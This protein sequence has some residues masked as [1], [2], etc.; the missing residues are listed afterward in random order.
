MSSAVLASFHQDLSQMLGF[1]EAAVYASSSSKLFW[2]LACGQHVQLCTTRTVM[3]AAK[4]QPASFR[5]RC[6]L[7]D[8]R[9]AADTEASELELAARRAAEQALADVGAMGGAAAEV[10]LLREARA[11][12]YAAA[13][14]LLY[15]QAASGRLAFLLVQVDGAQHFEQSHAFPGQ[16]VQAQQERDGAF[17]AAAAAQ[18]LSVARLHHADTEQ[19]GAVLAAALRQLLSGSR[20]FI[21][22]S[23]SYR[24]PLSPGQPCTIQFQ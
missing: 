24:Q 22:F 11:Q 14:L 21:A 19:Y 6:R 4:Q 2:R 12:R 17:N 16:S 9:R 18:R 5:M 20:P 13:D 8:G 15:C 7:C 23:P 3:N 1:D 10:R